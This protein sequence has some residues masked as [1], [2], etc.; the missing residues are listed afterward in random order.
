MKTT[1]NFLFNPSHSLNFIRNKFGILEKLQRP[2]LSKFSRQNPCVFVLSTGRVGSKTLASLLSQSDNLLTFHEPKPKLFSL[3]CCAYKYRH[4][5]NLKDT[6]VC[7][8][9]KTS[10]LTARDNLLSRAVYLSRGYVETSP[11]GTF[12][13]PIIHQLIPNSKFIHLIRDPKDVIRSGMRRGWYQGHAYDF[14]RIQPSLK[15]DKEK[16]E[17]YNAFQKNSWLWV[18]TNTLF[19]QL[20]AILKSGD[21]KV[22][23]FVHTVKF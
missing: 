20:T 7:D 9:F 11:Q 1:Y 6:I 18:E 17:T 23:S 5:L 10:F 2:D 19:Q 14:C 13:A 16:W 4:I 3:S 8:I 21:F 22:Q 12:L 15:V